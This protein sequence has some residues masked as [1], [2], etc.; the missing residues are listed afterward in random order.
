MTAQTDAGG[1]IYDIGYR[2]YDGPRLG[3]SGA[4]G[5]VVQAGVRAVFG[6]GRSGRAGSPLRRARARGG[7]ARFR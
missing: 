2:R 7:R 4:V 5:A 1:T 3:R 6:L